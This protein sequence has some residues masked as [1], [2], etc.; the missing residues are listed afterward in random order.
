[1]LFLSFTSLFSLIAF[2]FFI[3]VTFNTNNK[4]H[5]LTSKL[6]LPNN[7]QPRNATFLYFNLS[8]FTEEDGSSI[9]N[10]DRKEFQVRKNVRIY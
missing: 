8:M 3:L 4:R 1:M 7:K 9:N 10:D 5:C 2:L 6:R